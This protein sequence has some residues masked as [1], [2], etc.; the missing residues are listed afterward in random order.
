MMRKIGLLICAIILF[1]SGGIAHAEN[2]QSVMKR[3]YEV[4]QGLTS[5]TQNS[6]DN[7]TFRAGK[8]HMTVGTTV[9]LRYRKP[10]D[11][12]LSI[13]G[14]RIGTVV[15]TNHG[16]R[17]MQYV[18]N[19]NKYRLMPEAPSAAIFIETLRPLGII[20]IMDSLYYIAGKSLNQAADHLKYK[21]KVKLNGKLC[22]LMSATVKPNQI[23]PNT[24]ATVEFWV[25]S[26]NFLLKKIRWDV[27][28]VTRIVPYIK[29]VKKK[30]VLER[31]KVTGTETMTEYIVSSS[32][33]PS[34]TDSDF[35]YTLPSDAIEQRPIR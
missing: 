12:Y 2:A 16:G 1:A 29:V 8:Y 24:K 9:L 19:L 25:D 31:K 6:N 10:N 11:L 4:Y 20:S 27:T 3:L 34:M 26:Q 30:R 21:G 35:K 28:G 18:S 23:P 32:I 13:T 33:N 17:E 15:A 22:Y 14:P 7:D 5:F